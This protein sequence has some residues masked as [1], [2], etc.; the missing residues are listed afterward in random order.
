MLRFWASKLHFWR[1]SRRKASFLSFKASIL[2]EVSQKSFVFELQSFIFEGSLAEKLRFWSSKLHSWR[3]SSRKALFLSFKA[4]ILKDVSQKASFLRFKALFLTSQIRWQP[5]RLN[6]KF[7]NQIRWQPNHLN[8]RSFDNQTTWISNHST[9]KS[10]EFGINWEPKSLESQI[11]W[12]P[13]HLHLKSDDNQITWIPNQMTTKPFDS[14]FTWTWHQL[15]FEHWTPHT[16]SYRFIMVGNVR[17]RLA[18]SICYH[19]VPEFGWLLMFSYEVI[20]V[21]NRPTDG[22]VIFLPWLHFFSWQ[23]CDVFPKMAI[24]PHVLC[25]SWFSVGFGVGWG[26]GIITTQTLAP[27]LDLLLHFHMNLMLRC[28]IFSCISTW[29]WCSAAWSSLAFLP[30][31]DAPLLDLLLHFYLNLMLRCL[32]F[33]CISTWTWCSFAWSFLAFLNELDAPLLDLLL[34]FYLNLM[35]RCLIFSCNSTWT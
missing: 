2:K 23:A 11:T 9:S 22:R 13:N 32:I 34:H 7:D 18:R 16:S 27:L 26:G 31:L 3:K 20:V 14:Q 35:F 5:N 30:E 17:H 4:S 12:Q 24:L 10:I 19:S 33:S 6:L 28:L 1:K 8:P 15:T 25:F 21:G 29:T